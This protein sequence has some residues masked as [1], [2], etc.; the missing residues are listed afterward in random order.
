MS[1]AEVPHFSRRPSMRTVLTR[2]AAALVLACAVAPPASAQNF[3]MNLGYFALKG[4]DSR[5]NGDTLVANLGLDGRNQFP[6]VFNTD[7]FN[8]VTIQGEAFM[9]IGEFLEAGGGIGFYQKSVPSVYLDFTRPGGIEIAQELKLRV[10]PITAAVKYMPLGRSTSVQPYVGGG[11][12]I[13]LWRYSEIGDFLNADNSVVNP[14]IFG[15]RFIGSG[16]SVG[17]ILLFGV[18]V[19]IGDHFMTGGEARRQWSEGNLSLNDFLGDKID[20]GGWTYSWTL[21]FK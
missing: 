8:G 14:D 2:V 19:P 5:V 9:P 13:F 3:T 4:P 20:L 7:E 21:S 12:G 10:F 18:R 6:L 16:T 1:A 15:A 17:P 11:L